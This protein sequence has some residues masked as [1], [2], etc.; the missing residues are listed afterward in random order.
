MRDCWPA[1]GVNK[2]W[3]N[4]RTTPAACSHIV[5]TW[6][7][8]SVALGGASEGGRERGERARS[9]ARC[10]LILTGRYDKTRGKSLGIFLL[11]SRPAFLLATS[12]SS[13]SFVCLGKM[14]PEVMKWSVNCTPD[15]LQRELQ[16]S[17]VSRG[18]RTLQSEEV[19]KKKYTSQKLTRISF[20]GEHRARWCR[21]SI[22]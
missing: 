8:S 12:S 19:R 13:T 7:D 22:N 15:E 11:G 6:G 18:E 3:D 10:S 5:M 21:E 9:E 20:V 17:N 14:G 1:P 4:I 2:L 16:A